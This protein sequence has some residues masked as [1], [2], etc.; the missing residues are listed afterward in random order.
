MTIF[1]INKK[2]LLMKMY[3]FVGIG[4]K[5]INYYNTILLYTVIKIPRIN[6]FCITNIYMRIFL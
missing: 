3:Y 1:Q 5:N 4:G 2:L 6:I